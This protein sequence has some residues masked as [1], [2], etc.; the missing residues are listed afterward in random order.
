MW[1]LFWVSYGQNWCDK[2]RKQSMKMSL[3]TDEHSPDRFRVNGPLSQNPDFAVRPLSLHG[4]FCFIIYTTCT[5]IC[6]N[7][8]LSQDADSA[9]RSPGAPW[10]FV[11]YTIHTD[12]YVFRVNGPPRWCK[13]CRQIH[14]LSRIPLAIATQMPSLVMHFLYTPPCPNFIH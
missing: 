7:G 13:F 4:W 10:F 6:I 3:L 14:P 2:E 8:P 1:Q 12:T 5:C 11:V 9:F